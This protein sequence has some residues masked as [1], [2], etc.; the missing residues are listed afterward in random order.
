MEIS[1]KDIER[2]EK[3]IDKISS[4]EGCWLWTGSLNKEGYG[5][6]WLNGTM[7]RAHR[8]SYEL[9]GQPIP[10][11]HFIRHKCKP[12]NCINPEHLEPGTPAENTADRLRD[13]TDCRGEKHPRATLTNEQVREIK[14]LPKKRGDTKDIAA[15][16][17]V[18]K[19][20]IKDIRLGRRWS[21]IV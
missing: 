12:K 9:T 19:H 21:K 15:K 17:G 16:Y 3:M 10:E 1:K 18:S 2:F 5:Q 20:I 6:F 8:L 14:A 11:G 13:G 7:K 4:Q